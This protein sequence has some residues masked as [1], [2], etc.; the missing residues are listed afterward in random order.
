[1]AKQLFAIARRTRAWMLAYN[2]EILLTCSN[3]PPWQSGQIDYKGRTDLMIIL[4]APAFLTFMT[5]IFFYLATLVWRRPQQ[6]FAAEAP[7]A[8]LSSGTQEDVR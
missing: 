7:E 1:M 4:L 5:T 8:F 2:P 6:R 3:Y